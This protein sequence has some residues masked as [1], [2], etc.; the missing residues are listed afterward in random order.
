MIDGEAELNSM[1]DFEKPLTPLHLLLGYI[2]LTLPHP[3]LLD[4]PDYSEPATDLSHTTKHL[5][6]TSDNFYKHWKE[7]FA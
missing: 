4:D 5:I 3:P 6:K 2:V 7:V 1:D